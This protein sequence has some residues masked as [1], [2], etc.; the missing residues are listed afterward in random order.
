[1]LRP[2]SP[3]GN[4]PEPTARMSIA[5]NVFSEAAEN[6]ALMKTTIKSLL[7]LLLFV[8][9]SLA[10]RSTPDGAVNEFFLCGDPTKVM[11]VANDATLWYEHEA[12]STEA[13]LNADTLASDTKNK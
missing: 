12:W 8:S 9:P 3:R 2:E 7:L 6:Q 11:R 4:P 10:D 13:L 1:M 5:A